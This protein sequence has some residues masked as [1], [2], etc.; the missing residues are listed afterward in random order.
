MV[1]YI[2]QKYCMVHRLSFDSLMCHCI[3]VHLIVRHAA[4]EPVWRIHKIHPWPQQVVGNSSFN[5][6][7][8]FLVC[9][10]TRKDSRP[11]GGRQISCRRI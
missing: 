1:L 4:T 8:T 2:R 11:S 7:S 6:R 10:V 5:S 9:V 3:T